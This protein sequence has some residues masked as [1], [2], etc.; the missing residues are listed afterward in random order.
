MKSNI[1]GKQKQG[2]SPVDAAGDRGRMG[3]SQPEVFSRA[4]EKKGAHFAFA[5]WDR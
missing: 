5:K 4:R 1:T 3:I 2:Q